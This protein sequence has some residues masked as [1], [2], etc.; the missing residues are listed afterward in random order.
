MINNPVKNCLTEEG[1]NSIMGILNSV[2]K[3]LCEMKKNV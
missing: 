3:D 2:K 1:Y